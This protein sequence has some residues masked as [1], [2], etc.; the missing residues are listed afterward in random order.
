MKLFA[1]PLPV[2]TAEMVIHSYHFSFQNADNLIISDQVSSMFDGTVNPRLLEF[3]DN[4][5]LETLTLGNPIFLPFTN[6]S[7]LGDFTSYLQ[8]DPTNVVITLDKGVTPEDIYID[9]IKM[10]KKLGYKFAFKLSSTRPF[11]DYIPVLS[12]MDYIIVNQNK[13]N[14]KEALKAI[15]SFPNATSIASNVNTYTMFNLAAASGYDLFEGRFYRIPLSAG[16]DSELS[17]LKMLCVQL[18]NVVREE[19]FDLDEISKIVE[20]D[21]SLSVSMLQHINGQGFSSKISTIQHAAAML[22]QNELRKWV[23]SSASAQLGSDKPSEIN[24]LSLIRAKF[25]EQ[26]APLFKLE[27]EA[28]SLFLMG[29]FSVLDVLLDTS[30]E[31]AL[32]M[33][34]VSDDIKNA[35]VNFKGNYYPIYEFMQF[36]EAGDWTSVAR[37]MI[38]NNI[39]A[40]DLYKSYATTLEWYKDLTAS[41]E[42]DATGKEA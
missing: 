42:A 29:L 38:L 41:I 28:D 22:G 35:L 10:C 24:R 9:K 13:V 37:F 34:S 23:S 26:L 16:V 27:K 36:Y 1:V 6:I 12:L 2:F 21:I 19:N 17:P 8:I 5:G 15:K 4:I 30:I 7:L 31:E 25:A 20:K 39:A 14:K 33:V 18:L 3:V 11:E 40:E 32:R